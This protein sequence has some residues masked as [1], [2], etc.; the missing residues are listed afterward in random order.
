MAKQRIRRARRGPPVLRRMAIWFNLVDR[1]GT[2]VNFRLRDASGE[3]QLLAIAM[4]GVDS[5]KVGDTVTLISTKRRFTRK[6]VVKLA[7]KG[8]FENRHRCREDH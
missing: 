5:A 6:V 4:D 2:T 8:R 3:G 1:H 7:I